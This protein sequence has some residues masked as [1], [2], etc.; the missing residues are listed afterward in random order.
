MKKIIFNGSLTCQTAGA[1]KGFGL[2]NLFLFLLTTIFL[3]T[4]CSD[5]DG[6]GTASSSDYYFRASLDG[7]DVDFHTVNFQGG[8]DDNRWEHI[9][10]G[11][12][13]TSFPTD[14]SQIPP[15]L[16]FEIWRLGG[17]I[18][19]GTY[20]TPSE[21]NMIARYAV[22]TGNGTLLYNT[23]FS[24]DAFTVNIESISNDGIKGTFSGTVRSQAGV[25]IVVSEGSFNLPYEDIINP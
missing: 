18:T 7:R 6:S 10:I 19:P 14:G 16:D 3:F 23:S 4:A 9:V 20:T 2:L 21:P 5:D 15:S 17:D 1:Q 13:E 24:D 11:G 22:Q 25:A 8:G 12:Y